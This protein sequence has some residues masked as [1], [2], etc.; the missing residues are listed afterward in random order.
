MLLQAECT[1]AIL[2]HIDTAPLARRLHD[3]G[4]DL[5]VKTYP[6]GGKV[7]CGSRSVNVPAAN[8]YLSR[9]YRKG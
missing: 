2:A 7:A 6:A 1:A 5:R 3:A 8:K 9:E 4:T